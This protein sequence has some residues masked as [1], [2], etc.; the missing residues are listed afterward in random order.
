MKFKYGKIFLLG[1]GS[2]GFSLLWVVYNN[3]VPLFL[4]ERFGL[5]PAMIGFFMTLDNIAALLIQPPVGALS[6]RLRTP[7]GRRMPFILVGVPVAATAF[8]F[9][10]VAAALPVFVACT[11][12]LLLSMAF[13]RT[14]V[15]ALLADVTPSQYRSQANG[16]TNLMGGIGAIIGTLGGGALYAQNHAYPFWMGSGAVVLAA[17]ILLAFVREPKTYI[18]AAEEEPRFLKS[19]QALWKERERSVLRMLATIFFSYLAYNAIEA[20]F[21]LYAKNHLGLPGE[22]GAQLLGQFV[23]LLVLFA[24][25]AGMLGGTLGRRT[26]IFI[27]CLALM[28]V[29]LAIFLLPPATLLIPLASLPVVGVV[30]IIGLCLMAGG[31]AWAMINVN[32]LPMVVDMTDDLH[33]GTYTGFYYIAFTLAA[34]FGPN[35]N[36]W[37]VQ[38][39]GNNYNLIMLASP[40]FLAIAMIMLLGVHRGEAKTGA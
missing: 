28:T 37:I 7:L 38:L 31:M 25:P 24:L 23:L 13:W 8:G 26:S 16:V 12:T 15:V 35:I 5:Q 3:F 2:F 4:E 33:A 40:F 18:S 32:T 27:G 29:V 30:P 22:D 9:I 36:G 21:T 34:I 11:M 10:P 20:F 6:D 19:L 1:F 17:L 14:P 39:S